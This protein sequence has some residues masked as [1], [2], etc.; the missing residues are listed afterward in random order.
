MWYITK[1]FSRSG[2]SLG[3]ANTNTSQN[4]SFT[5]GT[6][7]SQSKPG[8][9][10]FGQQSGS[11]GFSFGTPQQQITTSGF[12]LGQT[13]TSGTQN[14]SFSLNTSQQTS[15]SNILGMNYI[16]YVSICRVAVV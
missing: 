9:L 10:T 1:F 6:A 4:T 8:S 2:F 5:L 14:P 13:S 11:G 16:D 7:T 3:S 15:Q 12:T